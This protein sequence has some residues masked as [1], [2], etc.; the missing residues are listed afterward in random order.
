MRFRLVAFDLDG[1]LLDAANRVSARTI[2]AIKRVAATGATI[3]LCSGRSMACMMDAQAQ[4]GLPCVILSC[5]GAAAFDA[6]SRPLYVDT[7]STEIVQTVLNTAERMERCVNLYDEVRG[8]IHARPT[9]SSHHELIDRY[10][11]RTGGKYNIVEAY[12][13]NAV[14]PCQVAV[15]GDDPAEIH[16]TLESVLPHHDVQVNSY[17][18][19]VECIPRAIN[20]GIGLQ[21]L[22]KHLD[23]PLAAT[24]AFGD[25]ANDLEFVQTAGFG[26]AMQ[27]AIDQVKQVAKKVTASSHDADGVAIELEEMLSQGLFGPSQTN[28]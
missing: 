8:I 6:A 2:A 4:L 24:V 27:N 20:K 17:S 9:H 5:N 18:Y 14:A 22:A 12:D 3:S 13:L 19:F 15:L 23:I 21:R 25:G 10:G 7:M 11:T 26:I 16:S 1:T 28:A